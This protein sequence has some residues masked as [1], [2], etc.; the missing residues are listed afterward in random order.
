MHHIITDILTAQVLA[1]VNLEFCLTR[2]GRHCFLHYE[3]LLL[4]ASTCEQYPKTYVLARQVGIKIKIFQNEAQK[5]KK[6]E[7]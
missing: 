7:K 1:Q 6:D 4:L 3:L 2:F 5:D